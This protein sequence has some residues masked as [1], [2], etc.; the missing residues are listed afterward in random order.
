MLA[1]IIKAPS[2]FKKY[3]IEI[4]SELYD[5]LYNAFSLHKNVLSSFSD[6]FATNELKAYQPKS[7]YILKRFEKYLHCYD[8]THSPQDHDFD[9]DDQQD[10]LYEF[11]TEGDHCEE[12][13]AFN[14]QLLDAV[15]SSKMMLSKEQDRIIDIFHTHFGTGSSKTRPII[16]ELGE[17]LHEGKIHLAPTC[18]ISLENTSIRF[19]NNSQFA[20]KELERIKIALDRLKAYFKQ[21]LAKFELLTS[22]IVPLHQEG[23]VS[24]SLEDLPSVSCINIS[25]RDDIDLL[26]D[27]LHENGHHHMNFYLRDFEL[28]YEDDEEIYYSPWRRALR[29]IRGL[30]HAV[31]TFYFA[32]ELFYNLIIN[33]IELTDEERIK[34]ES[35]FCQEY[36]MIDLCK[37]QI[38]TAINDEKISKQGIKLIQEIFTLHDEHSELFSNLSKNHDKEL[39]KIKS[40]AKGLTGQ[41]N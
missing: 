20:D 29:P 32:E 1:S 21:G 40:D 4:H 34:V 41:E 17:V 36:L 5:E 24:Y 38:D 37:K 2:L 18:E 6:L 35:R 16:I 39:G 25:E 14:T 15:E 9:S 28:I 26:D 27:L 30:Y 11:W 10:Y 7:F 8:I 22:T 31:F 3:I 19:V 33:N 13:L 12:F 23:I